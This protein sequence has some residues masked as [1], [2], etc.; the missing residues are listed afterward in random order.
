MYFFNN[1]DARSCYTLKVQLLKA[2]IDPSIV[3]RKRRE[4]CF[5]G[6][7]GIEGVCVERGSE[8]ICL[9]FCLFVL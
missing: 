9:D 3:K 6:W 5:R 8:F 7:I 2:R 4:S 1:I